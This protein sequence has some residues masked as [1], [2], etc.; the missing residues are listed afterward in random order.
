MYY[1]YLLYD[2]FASLFIGSAQIMIFLKHILFLFL[3]MKYTKFLC[4]FSFA[5]SLLCVL[6]VEVGDDEGRER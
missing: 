6:F 2:D 1:Y 3:H 5:F 4:V